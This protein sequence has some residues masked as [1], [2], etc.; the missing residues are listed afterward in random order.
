MAANIMSFDEE[1]LAE[2]AKV[3]LRSARAG[4]WKHALR[5]VKW[6]REL[7]GD[8]E[9]LYLLITAAYIHDIGWSGIAPKGKINLDE[10]LLLEPKANENSSRMILKIL[11]FAEFEIK[12]VQRLITA[13]DKH[14]ARKD[15]EEIIVDADNLSKLCIGHLKEKYQPKSWLKL[16]KL[17]DEE[18]PRRIKTNKG[19][20]IFSELLG[21]LKR[22][23]STGNTI[24]IKMLILLHGTTIMHKS[25]IGKNRKER[26]KQ[27]LEREKSV[28]DYASYVPIG[29]AVKK[30]AGWKQQ[31]A[32]IIYLSSH[33][34]GKDVE[35]DKI[36]LKRFNFPMGKVAFRK[37]G[38]SYKNIAEELIPDIL[39]EDDCESIG[40]K[41]EMT[42]T[43]V[44]PEI[45]KKIKSIVVKEFEGLDHLSDNAYSLLTSR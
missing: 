10:M 19:K 13:A 9:D 5:V 8:R 42:I 38:A 41:K 7:G 37:K 32:E 17:W 21:K 11:E 39:I 4:D 22:K 36:V 28:L 45:K 29:N 2:I 44:S 6:V 34:K 14:R 1:K 26:V 15:D 24:K 35:K 20:E 30:L 33:E 27:S 16:V 40:G 3:Y 18:L 23:L 12:T 25:A 43:F 31:G